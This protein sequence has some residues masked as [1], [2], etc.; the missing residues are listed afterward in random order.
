M[1][2]K[3]SNS[4]GRVPHKLVSP[5]LLDGKGKKIGLWL[6]VL[7][8]QAAIGGGFLPVAVLPSLSGSSNFMGVMRIYVEGLEDNARA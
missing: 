8:T 3:S 2:V 4:S 7:V 1:L 5:P 6:V